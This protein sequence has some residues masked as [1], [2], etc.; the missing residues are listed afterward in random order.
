VDGVVVTDSPTQ[1]EGA[2][3]SVVSA[4]EGSVTARLGELPPGSMRT[5]RFHTRSTPAAGGE[6]KVRAL[7]MFD[8]PAK[9]GLRSET[10]ESTLTRGAAIYGRSQFTFTP[11]FDVLKTELLPSDEH[12]LRA[13]IDS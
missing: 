5:F 13:L 3:T 8:S 2:G 7:A 10:I 11:R 9:S 6:L 1:V 4:G 12:A